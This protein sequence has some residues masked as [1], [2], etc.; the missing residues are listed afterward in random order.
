MHIAKLT[1]N[2]GNKTTRSSTRLLASIL[3][4]DAYPIVA[5]VD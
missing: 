1:K 4:I 5:I 3:L 2:W